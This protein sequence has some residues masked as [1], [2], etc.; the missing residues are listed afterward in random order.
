M[1][2]GEER[3]RL[4][5][6]MSLSAGQSAPED[7]IFDK[8]EFKEELGRG[9]FS[10]VKLALD[11]GNAEKVAVKVIDKTKMSDQYKKNLAMETNILRK[12]DHPHII[13]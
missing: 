8:Y 2:L 9:A 7:D 3:E 6:N 12:V 4:G 5:V 11:K 10:I 13:R 1:H